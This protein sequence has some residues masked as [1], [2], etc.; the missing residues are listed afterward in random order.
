MFR[1]LKVGRKL[2]P[3]SPLALGQQGHRQEEEVV[4][5]VEPVPETAHEVRANQRTVG[6]VVDVPSQ[7][8]GSFLVPLA[9]P[10]PAVNRELA[11]EDFDVR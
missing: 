8:V 6:P 2:R 5:R 9:R 10:S 7:P 11:R 3:A 1:S 4:T